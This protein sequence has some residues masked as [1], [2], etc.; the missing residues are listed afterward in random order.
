MERKQFLTQMLIGS[1]LLLTA[2]ALFNSC[3]KEDD[4]ISGGNNGSSQSETTIDLSAS[5]Y[6]VLSA[7]GGYAYKNNFI[8]IRTGN[9]SYVALSKICTH[10]GCTVEYSQSANNLPCP[11]HGSKYTIDGS[12]ING[13]ATAAL[14]K[15]SV[16]VEGALL[17]IS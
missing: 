4:D 14:K 15:Y 9:T 16:K 3:S 17:T 11:C 5:E 1:S 6:S 8:V 10:M 13:P 12:V 7:V 2:P